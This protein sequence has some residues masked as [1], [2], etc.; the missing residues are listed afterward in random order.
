MKDNM[1][2]SDQRSAASDVLPQA[3]TM[4]LHDKLQM[5]M[6]SLEL[7]KLG[8]LEETEKLRWQI[9]IPPYLGPMPILIFL[10]LLALTDSMQLFILAFYQRAP[11][12]LAFFNY[13]PL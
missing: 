11:T 12:S 4:S 9:P 7:E 8:K 3:E 5:R 10:K 13:S 1:D 2:A 6:R